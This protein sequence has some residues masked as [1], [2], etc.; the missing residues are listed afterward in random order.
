MSRQRNKRSIVGISGSPRRHANSEV[1]LD[2]ALEGAALEGAI[3]D[4]IV[5]NELCLM[6]CQGCYRCGKK[7][8]CAVKDDMKLVYKKLDGADGLVIA[9]PIYFG[10]L[11]AQLKIMIDRFESYWVRKYVLKRPKPY[12]RRSGIFLCCAANE[13][14][15]FFKNAMDITKHFF[16][17]L[18][19]EY[20]GA[21]FCGR[22]TGPGDM[23]KR[24]QTLDRA[25]RM[26][27]M[28][29]KRV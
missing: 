1:L 5:L 20:R 10:S 9:S 29:A 2:R 21:L 8:V 27:A 26:G 24:P 16:T 22:L 13:N 14:R 6:P 15:K 4:K 18:D 7:G 17:T 25:F 23:I 19:I 3:V 12:K 11:T 28:L